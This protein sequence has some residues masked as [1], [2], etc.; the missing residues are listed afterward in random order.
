MKT[1]II[2]R[3]DW[4]VKIEN[5]AIK[6]DTQTIP[7]QL[8]DLLILNHKVTCTTSDL[9]K[10]SQN[11]VNVLIVSFNNSNISILHSANA[12]N[13]ALKLQ[14]YNSLK[15]NLEFAK[16]FVTNKIITH[17]Q[18][19]KAMGFEIDSDILMKLYSANTLEE[20][21]GIEGSY[22]RWYFEKYFQKISKKFHK[23]K[24]SKRPPQDPLNALLSYWYSLFYNIISIELLK[25][26][27]EPA[28]G[29]L[30]KPFRSHFALSSDFLELFRAAINQAV[31][32]IFE[33]ELLEINDF[34]KKG[35][36]YLKYS[37]RKKV[38][39]EFVALIDIL[40]PQLDKYIANV[41]RMIDEADSHY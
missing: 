23:G 1:A 31:Y 22:A 7:L 24:R 25:Y 35:G 41:R 2:D 40:K 18:Q 12:K 27:F 11:D 34:S 4:V 36:V 26:G 13:S 20:I 30:H 29:Y 5:N 16:Y 14:Q 8:I 37:G 17:N 9:L 32:K 19:I 15:N 28:M 33:N 3:K 21:L 10:F 38:W 6:L 39:Q